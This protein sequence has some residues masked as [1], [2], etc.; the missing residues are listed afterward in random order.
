MVQSIKPRNRSQ[1]DL[2]YSNGIRSDRTPPFP[3][4]ERYQTGSRRDILPPTPP[5]EPEVQR[6]SRSQPPQ[7][8]QSLSAR[9]SGSSYTSSPQRRRLPSIEDDIE[10]EEQIRSRLNGE[11][12]RRSQSTG[13]RKTPQ[14]RRG[15]SRQE[16][17]RQDYYGDVYDDY[18]DEG[19]SS[20]VTFDRPDPFKRSGTLRRAPSNLS[21]S[22]SVRNLRRDELE[23]ES[24][25][26]DEE[27]FQ[28]NEIACSLFVNGSNIAKELVIELD[29]DLSIRDFLAQVTDRLN[30]REVECVF[31]KA[32]G[33][34]S[35]LSHQQ[36]MKSFV[37]H[38][39]NA[40]EKAGTSFGKA[41]VCFILRKRLT[42]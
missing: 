12:L 3:A 29:G 39:R 23:S 24:E 4:Q 13:G 15:G 18:I 26:G 41:D 34:L 40:A 17:S 42:F 9:S 22:R 27:E 16:R 8:S 31:K 14:S 1:S 7:R 32:D 11:K 21:R 6:R 37:L 20:T 19:R 28:M 36:D 35:E 25:Y 5:S 33:Q 38:A 10:D 2:T 30:V